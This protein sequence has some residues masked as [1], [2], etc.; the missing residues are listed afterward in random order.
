[1]I[2]LRDITWDNFWD[3]V[4][5]L[6]PK[7]SQKDFLPSNAIFMAQAW[8]N[9]KAGDPHA[10]FAIYHE[11][12][13]IGFTK[14]VFVAKGE[15]PFCFTEDTYYLDAMMI[16]EKYQGKGYG[17]AAL[18]QILA[19]MKSRPWGEAGSIKLSCYDINPTAAKLYENFGFVKTNNFIDKGRGLR[20]YE[21]SQK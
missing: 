19:F 16:D 14:I 6:N 1:M 3:I 13:L 17:K 11:N 7:E 18:T 21:L 2:E 4:K 15:K 8:L 10:C 9:L 12:T 5:N 20:L